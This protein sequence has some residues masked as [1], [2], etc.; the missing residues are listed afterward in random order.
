MDGDEGGGGHLTRMQSHRRNLERSQADAARHETVVAAFRTA[1][2]RRRGGTARH[3]VD[4]G[5]VLAA[6]I[7]T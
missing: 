1:V 2:V 5:F 6:L 3:Q 4:D 7:A